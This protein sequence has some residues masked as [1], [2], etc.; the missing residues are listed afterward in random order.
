MSAG[1]AQHRGFTLLELL[2]SVA[3][4]MTLTTV[5]AV[6]LGPLSTRYRTQQATEL[7]AQAVVDARALARSYGRC[8]HLE[9]ASSAGA[10]VA[11]GSWGEAVRIQRRNSAD[12]ES[13]HA[14]AD[15]DLVDTIPLPA[16]IQVQVP[17]GQQELIWRPGGYTKTGADTQLQ[18]GT[19][20]FGSLVVVKGFGPSCLFSI[21]APGACP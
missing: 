3:V 11:V 14:P 13:A 10:A 4:L 8:V 9:V 21:G 17:T 16:G 18:V 2:V 15:L 7:V 20:P 19:A 6:S 1:S 12:C 5:A